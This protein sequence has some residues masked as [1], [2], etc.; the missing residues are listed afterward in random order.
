MI[1]G[2]NQRT[3]SHQ[4]DG[5]IDAFRV[6]LGSIPEENRFKKASEWS[7]SLVK[8]DATQP[9][10]K[11]LEWSGFDGLSDSNNPWQNAM[12]DL[13]HV[14]LNSNEFLYLH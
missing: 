7:S 1:G 10:D 5:S 12:T 9:L 14:L 3:P 2:L 11:S 8:W 4:W 6:A 13:C